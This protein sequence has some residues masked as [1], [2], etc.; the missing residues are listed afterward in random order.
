[1]VF[2]IT[3]LKKIRK[4]LNLTQHQFAKESQVSQSM[5]AKIESGKLDPTYSYVKKIEKAIE[6][7]TKINEEKITAKHIMHKGAITINKDEKVKNV[8]KIFSKNNI[9]QIPIIERNNVI[10]LI[11]E[12]SIVNHLEKDLI[13]KTAEEIM[14]ESPPLITSLAKIEIITSLLKFYPILIVQE[15][16][17][18]IGVITKADILKNLR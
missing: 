17:K 6:N 2:D 4:Q 1:M 14:E 7:L 3:H 8:L 12:S 11:T 5:I 10:G 9:S 15:K 16:G 18:L 13:N